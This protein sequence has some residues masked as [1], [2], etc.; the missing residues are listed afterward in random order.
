MMIV[1]NKF[2]ILFCL[3]LGWITAAAQTYPVQVSTVVLPPYSVHLSDYTTSDKLAVHVLFN[4]PVRFELSVKLKVTIEGKNITLSTKP[5]FNPKPIYLQ[6]GFPE[7]LTGIDLAPYFE[8]NN[9]NF[10]GLDRRTFEQKAA[11][12]EGVYRI[13][14]E[15]W[16]YS[17]N[18]K[19]SNTGCST[20]W[21]ILNDPPIINYPKNGEKIKILDQQLVIFNWTPRHTG[22]PNAAFTTEYAFELVE[23]RGAN[24]NPNNAILTSP[25]IYTT[26]THSTSIYYSIAETP[27]IPG[28]K[29]AFRVKAKAIAGLDELDLFKNNGYSEVFTFTYGDYCNAPEAIKVEAIS[30][31]SIKASWNSLPTQTS[32]TIQY[33]ENKDKAEWFQK[34]S[35][36]NEYTFTSLKPETEYMVQVIGFCG[37]VA[38]ENPQSY[39]V[40]TKKSDTTHF[41][42]GATP[43][44]VGSLSTELVKSLSPGDFIES[45]NFKVAL[46]EVKADGETF[47]GRGIAYIPWFKL[48]GLKVEF[49]KIKVNKDKKV[50]NGNINSIQ[51]DDSKWVYH[52]SAD[53]K[54]N[55]GNGSTDKG[56]GNTVNGGVKNDTIKVNGSNG[57]TPVVIQTNHPVITIN[58]N[59]GTTIVDGTHVTIV[60]KGQTVTLV[61]GNHQETTLVGGSTEP[62]ASGGN[63]S[64]VGSSGGQTTGNPLPP[65][66]LQLLK[67]AVTALRKKSDFF[68]LSQM[69]DNMDLRIANIETAKEKE[70]TRILSYTFA[71]VIE[72]SGPVITIKE[73]IVALDKEVIDNDRFK[74]YKEDEAKYNKLK[75]LQ[76][77]CQ[78]NLSDVQLNVL[79]GRLS[80]ENKEFGPYVTAAKTL[81][82]TKDKMIEDIIVSIQKMVEAQL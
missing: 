49:K 80:I 44:Q 46:I 52:G 27:L 13:C 31:T 39:T 82:L 6:S 56:I 17:Q 68:P 26:T 77:F 29:Y 9:L 69:K 58:S 57:S 71:P 72:F 61:D 81:G 76:V 21:M 64:N 25:P 5:E 54:P 7:R 23:V 37:V 66:S 60:D 40:T 8:P 79:A 75:I 20:V 11:L 51:S 35:L 24:Q 41:A 65:E 55:E 50:I 12:P 34:T 28:L 19:V 78:E 3:I 15:V 16:E 43:D 45:S 67:D 48:A 32:F 59:G 22:S 36:V 14:I 4:D 63:A 62:V 47:T 73:D 33:K 74:M 70:R 1:K 38:N 18:K 42:C 30:P 10:Q 53:P 2:F